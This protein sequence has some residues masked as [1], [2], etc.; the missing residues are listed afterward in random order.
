MWWVDISLVD[1]LLCI[2]P[3]TKY[4]EDAIQNI[5][6]YTCHRDCNI[7]AQGEFYVPAKC[8]VCH[9]LAFLDAIFASFGCNTQLI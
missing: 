6:C 4:S 8:I 5:K 9:I 7:I 3:Y 1:I 2:L